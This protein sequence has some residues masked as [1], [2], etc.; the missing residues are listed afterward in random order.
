MKSQVLKAEKGKFASITNFLPRGAGPAQKST[1]HLAGCA[2]N[3]RPG[4]YGLDSAAVH[5]DC[6]ETRG[7]AKLNPESGETHR[8]KPASADLAFQYLDFL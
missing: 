4:R 7:Q 6:C 5:V 3:S 8:A 2:N 1:Y